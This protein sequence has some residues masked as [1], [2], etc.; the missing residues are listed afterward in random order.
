MSTQAADIPVLH[1]EI[2]DEVAMVDYKKTLFSSSIKAG[3]SPR[4]SKYSAPADKPPQGRLGGKAETRSIDRTKVSDRHKFRKEIEG[5]VQEKVEDYGV[6]DRAEE[7]DGESAAGISDL[8]GDA[9][10]KTLEAFKQGLE[11]T[12]LSQQVQNEDAYLMNEKGDFEHQHLTAGASF[13]ADSSPLGDLAPDA[14]YRPPAA[15]NVEVTELADFDETAV[16]A[17]IQAKA[18]TMN[19]DCNSLVFCT[20][21]FQTHFDTFLDEQAVEDG[22]VALRSFKFDGGKALYEFGIKQYKTSFGLCSLKPTQ[23]LNA[24]RN[25]GAVDADGLARTL[26][27]ATTNG[28]ATVVVNNTRGLQPFMRI[29]GTNIPAGAYILGVTDATHIEISANATGTASGTTL[30]LGYLDHALF[31][32]MKYFEKRVGRKGIRDVDMTPDQ[33]GKQGYVQGFFSYFCALPYVQGK[34]F[35]K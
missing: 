35:Q 6:T 21:D 4:R 32:E 24:T 5:I 20:Y 15:L 19:S 30:T 25:F 22:K 9:Y 11:M 17:F 2:S 23:H 12:G 10:V 34:V 28:E 18:E 33:S 29:K 26:T 7:I 8:V 13:W 31:L 1:E 27:G 16:R 14:T 3:K